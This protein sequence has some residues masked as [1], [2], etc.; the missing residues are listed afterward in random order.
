MYDD[1]K[2]RSYYDE[3]TKRSDAAVDRIMSG[4]IKGF[5]QYFGKEKSI[6][7]FLDL[8]WKDLAKNR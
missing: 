2:L 5:E 3:I 7:E 1:V 6:E 8:Y 4:N